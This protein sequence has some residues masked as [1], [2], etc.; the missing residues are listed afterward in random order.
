MPY[1]TF[2]AGDYC[3]YVNP[4]DGAQRIFCVLLIPIKAG[5]KPL[6]W[7]WKVRHFDANLKDSVMPLSLLRH[8]SPLEVL[9]AQGK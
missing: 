1:Q 7:G 9:A 6:I 4:L 3:Y 8:A 5:W 2:E